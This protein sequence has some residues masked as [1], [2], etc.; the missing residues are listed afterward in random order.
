M[1]FD[2][3]LCSVLFPPIP[4]TCIDKWEYPECQTLS[5]EL[6]LG[7]QGMVRVHLIKPQSIVN[8]L[9][10][11]TW[12]KLIFKRFV[13]KKYMAGDCINGPKTSFFILCITIDS[14]I[15]VPSTKE[16]EFISLHFTLKLGQ[17]ICSKQQEKTEMMVR[18]LQAYFFKVL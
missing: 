12:K 6:L 17:V 10:G 2:L 14:G 4:L 7:N 5:Q 9:Y 16:M 3:Y 8:T 11:E 18:Q 1:Q 15:P 13:K